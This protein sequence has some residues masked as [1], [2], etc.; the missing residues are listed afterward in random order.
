MAPNSR[1]PFTT[2]TTV[3][4]PGSTHGLGTSAL[5]V[6]VYDAAVPAALVQSGSPTIHPTSFDVTLTFLQPQSGAVVLNASIP[7]PGLAGNYARTFTV[8]AGTPL[9]IPGTLHGL[10]TPN[11][12][13]AFYDASTPRVE[14]QPG[15]MTVHPATHDVTF[16]FAQ[17]QS[18]LVVLC[19]HS[20]TGGTPN[21]TS[22]FTAQTSVTV[23]GATHGLSTSRLL[24]QV[25]DASTPRQ[26]VRPGRV[27]VHPTTYDVTLTFAQPQSGTAVL[28]GS[29][30]APVPPVSV[31]QRVDYPRE[32]HYLR[33]D[34]VTVRI[35]KKR[36]MPPALRL[37]PAGGRR[38]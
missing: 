18:G 35:V 37:T 5:L 9:V 32:V 21:S 33:P 12:V 2:Q 17:A 4:I 23:F 28:N 10:D 29:V 19:G 30:G 22:G 6:G 14:I 24:V 16:L 31:L 11:L 7:A 13:P 27:T 26:R 20:S 1:F 38:P 34:G 36:P 15:Q 25:Y 3:T 8:P